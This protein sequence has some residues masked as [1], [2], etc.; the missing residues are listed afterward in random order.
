MSREAADYKAFFKDRYLVEVLEFRKYYPDIKTLNIEYSTLKNFD[1]EA[2]EWLIDHPD[3]ELKY[4]KK[5]LGEYDD[6]QKIG[7]DL[8]ETDPDLPDDNMSKAVISIRGLPNTIPIHK[9][10]QDQVNKL[11]SIEGRM[12]RIAPKYQKLTTGAFKCQRCG[13]ITFFEQPDERYIEPFICQSDECGRKGPFKLLP[14]QSEYEDQQKVGL[15]DLNESAKPGQPLREIIVLLRT[16]ELIGS[17][18]G[19]GSQCTITGILKLQQKTGAGG[20]LS[21]YKPYLQAV[22]IEPKETEID[23]SISEA[24]KREF[25]E[26]AA[27]SDIIQTLINSTAPDILG[28]AHIKAALLCSIVSGADNP[29]FREYMH[30]ILCGDPGTGKS[31]LLKS[32]RALVPRAQ[33]SAGRGSSVAGLTVAVIKDELSGSGYTAQAGA[34]VL[35]DRG[36]MVLDEADK[37]EKE[38]FQALNTALEES[39]IEIHKGGIN[40]KYNT[41]CSVIA[42]CNP[43]NIRFDQ[44][45]QLT[46]Q[47]S[48][49]G[50][51]LSRFD[52]IFK[53]Q[54]IPDPEKDKAIAEHQ[55]KQW[56]RYEGSDQEQPKE[57]SLSQEKLSKYLQYAR[58]ITA[59]TDPETRQAI[60]DYFL[61]LRKAGKNKDEPI[62]ITARQN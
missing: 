50:D 58:T 4:L 1:S 28:H 23:L 62:T 51:T 38:D 35:A 25:K 30:L 40:Q 2:G 32:I 10:G 43:K 44:Y 56:A 13:D 53:I 57:N 47:I 16:T 17:I 61:T 39:F 21:E 18:P 48:I 12:T 11:I 33:Y 19:M 52:L 42:L 41:R 37:L 59:R 6:Q 27:N 49:P 8:S 5:A 15:Q 29:Q 22:H 24:E 20:K 14:E 9:I 36:L 55:A 45:E 34:L 31:A 3:R 46:K 7:L 60:T 54:D 26:L